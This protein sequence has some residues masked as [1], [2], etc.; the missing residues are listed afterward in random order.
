MRASGCR[1]FPLMSGDGSVAAVVNMRDISTHLFDALN[2]FD[3]E[4]RKKAYVTI[5]PRAVS[6]ARPLQI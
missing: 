2:A 4:P 1:N 5:A 6:I 3:T